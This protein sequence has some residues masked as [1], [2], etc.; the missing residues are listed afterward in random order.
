MKYLLRSLLALLLLATLPAAVFAQ[1][2]RGLGGRQ[3]RLSQLENAKIAYLTDKISL[4]QDQAQ[5]FWPVYNEFTDKR[6]DLNKRLRLLRMDNADGL[7][8]Q[9]IK[10]N[11]TQGLALRQSEVNLEKEYF[12]KF[13]KVLTIR[14]VGKLFMAER[15]FTKE[16]LKRVAGAGGAGGAVGAGADD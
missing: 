10:D 16:V 12:D 15:Q 13:Q 9:Q 1:G 8:D 2:G 7:T 6:R 4:T 3:G 11:L 5:K 14:Q